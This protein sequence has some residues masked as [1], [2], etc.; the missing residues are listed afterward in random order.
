L[1]KRSRRT[2]YPSGPREMRF[3]GAQAEDWV[4]V[5]P[6]TETTVGIV[7]VRVIVPVRFALR[8]VVVLSEVRRVA[9]GSKVEQEPVPS[10]EGDKEGC[11][12]ELTALSRLG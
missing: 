4:V 11:T 1:P 8:V 10:W 3:V 9:G 5:G 2:G 12:E 6:L 7:K